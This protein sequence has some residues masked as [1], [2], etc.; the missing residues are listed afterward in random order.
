MILEVLQK[1][2][3]ITVMLLDMINDA[4]DA[5]TDG[6]FNNSDSAIFHIKN[7]II[8]CRVL[9]DCD[10]LKKILSKK[11]LLE[12]NEIPIVT[13][14]NVVGESVTNNIGKDSDEPIEITEAKD[15]VIQEKK[16]QRGRP[17]KIQ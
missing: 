6:E 7:Q 3:E 14:E 2:D 4:N 8:L 9:N 11:Y 15:L 17:R 1:F 12:A 10:K 13:V 16:K 5:K